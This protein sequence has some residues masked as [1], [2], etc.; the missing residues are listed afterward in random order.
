MVV[1]YT[2]IIMLLLKKELFHVA[3][4]A[5]VMPDCDLSVRGMAAGSTHRSP[6]HRRGQRST[7]R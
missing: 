5:E 1:F 6:A 2:I 4:E 3:I 7:T